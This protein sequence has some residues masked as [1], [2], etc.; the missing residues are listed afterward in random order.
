MPRI[1]LRITRLL[2]RQQRRRIH[3]NRLLLR[4]RLIRKHHRQ[5]IKLDLAG[6]RRIRLGH[7]YHRVRRRP[8]L[9]QRLFLRLAPLQDLLAQGETAEDEKSQAADD[10]AD[11][12]GGDVADMVAV[13]GF[14]TGGAGAGGC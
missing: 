2:S 1:P 11:G 6:R 3:P 5:P 10:A 9:Q 8:S 13:G 7:R 14:G 12:D 4:R